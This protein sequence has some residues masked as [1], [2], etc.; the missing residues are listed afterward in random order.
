MKNGHMR[1]WI[2]FLGAL[3][4]G[5]LI[6]IVLPEKPDGTI[7]VGAIGALWALTHFWHQHE[8]EKNRFFFQLFVQYNERYDKLN[9][10][11][12]AIQESTQDLTDDE[13]KVVVDYFNLCAEEFLFYSRGYIPEDVWRAWRNGMNVFAGSSA[14]RES[15]EKERGSESYYGFDF[16]DTN[17]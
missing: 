16:L 12:Q 15:W 17:G 6:Y 5:S 2:W 3:I 7:V 11:L 10:K 13:R 1:A 9:N 8:L 14:F 4:V